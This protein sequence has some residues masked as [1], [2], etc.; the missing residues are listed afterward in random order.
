MCHLLFHKTASASQVLPSVGCALSL[1]QLQKHWNHQAGRLASKLKQDAASSC[2]H[3]PFCH[4]RRLKLAS[5]PDVEAE[6]D[7]LDQIDADTT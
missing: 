6:P 7:S 3:M 1:L 2:Q 4:P 5:I